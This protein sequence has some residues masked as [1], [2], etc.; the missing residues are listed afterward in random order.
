MPVFRLNGNMLTFVDS[1]MHLGH[2]ITADVMD[3]ADIWQRRNVLIG[4]V[5]K[6]LCHFGK[7]DIITKNRLLSAYCSSHYGAELWDLD[8]TTL[9]AYGAAWRT[10]LRRVW[11]LPWNAH[12]DLVS[13]L[14]VT[15][16]VLDT[17]MQ[18]FVNFIISCLQSSNELLVFIIQHSMLDLQMRSYISRNL[19]RCCELFHCD[20]TALLDNRLSARV[21]SH[22]FS[23]RTSITDRVNARAALELI[24]VREGLLRLDTL[25]SDEIDCF[26]NLLLSN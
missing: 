22:C 15:V 19:F 25:S 2:L 10:G 23:D 26:L 21:C 6:L 7:L 9:D 5:N 12:G 16:P 1:Y 11:R 8:C 14:S 4:Q 24:F 3:D 18:R 20:V 13:L 17:I